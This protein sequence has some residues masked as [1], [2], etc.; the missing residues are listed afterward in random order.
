VAA[1]FSTPKSTA[2]SVSASTATKCPATAQA[3]RKMLKLAVEPVN[4]GDP[5]PTKTRY[6]G[7]EVSGTVGIRFAGE[8]DY[9]PCDGDIWVWSDRDCIVQCL[10]G[11]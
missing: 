4:D 11:A 9:I 7:P 3:S 10:E 8:V 5:M 1:Y 6:G 2:V